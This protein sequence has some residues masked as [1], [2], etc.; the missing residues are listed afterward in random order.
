MGVLQRIE[1][2]LNVGCG[3]WILGRISKVSIDRT[4]VNPTGFGG[5]TG[6]SG[7]S[8]P[9]GPTG[10]GET[11]PTGPSGPSG[12][13]GPTGAGETGPT[14]NQGP[15]GPSGPTGP[16]GAGET[17]P[18]GLTG[19]STFSIVPDDFATPKAAIDA[20]QRRIF[21]KSGSYDDTGA[22]AISLS[23]V[24]TFLHI[25]GEGPA[26]T[27]WAFDSFVL[28]T[29]GVSA[30]FENL[31]LGNGAADSGITI[32]SG[33]SLTCRNIK[34]DTSLAGLLVASAAQ[35]Q[36][37]NG[38]KLKIDRLDAG[39]A[40]VPSGSAVGVV[41]D[42]LVFAV[43]T[44]NKIV[45]KDVRYQGA[46][47]N[48]RSFVFDLCPLN[49]S[50]GEY[51]LA[52]ETIADFERCEI[53]V[54]QNYDKRMWR[55]GSRV[56]Q[57][58]AVSCRGGTDQGATSAFEANVSQGDSFNGLAMFEIHSTDDNNGHG[59]KVIESCQ[60]NPSTSGTLAY[61]TAFFAFG[62]WTT[63][64]ADS[65]K[66]TLDQIVLRGNDQVFNSDAVGLTMARKGVE[67]TLDLTLRNIFITESNLQG[68][69]L[70]GNPEQF[71]VEGCALASGSTRLAAVSGSIQTYFE[72][73]AVGIRVNDN[74]LDGALF[75]GESLS[76]A[77][78][79]VFS[80]S[81]SG[82]TCSDGVTF[83][84]DSTLSEVA[85]GLTI[86]SNVFRDSLILAGDLV[87]TSITANSFNWDTAPRL[88]IEPTGE[89][90]NL[91]IT[92]NSFNKQ[93]PLAA[94]IVNNT[95]AAKIETLN[96]S[97]NVFDQEHSGTPISQIEIIN[98][99][100]HTSTTTDLMTF[101]NNTG[102]ISTTSGTRVVIVSDNANGRHLGSTELMAQVNR[103]KADNFTTGW[104]PSGTYITQNITTT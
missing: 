1:F 29:S 10:A 63:T 95:V 47:S 93:G 64:P 38:S 16:T 34:V 77:S 89:I 33:A 60:F 52:T 85:D 19:S 99:A 42:S 21:V 57:V 12:P 40:G 98:F 23:A 3:D 20:G 13:T 8:G 90:R 32:N 83:D 28:A 103:F 73:I 65:P 102:F 71:S 15:T 80:M 101:N 48:P 58:R 66:E 82:N 9:T 37:L 18:T 74:D 26:T 24:T 55:L 36:V 96:I 100:L 54:D 43:G 22:G 51:D 27:S 92:G 39:F 78:S 97:G 62:S 6:P 30:N 50:T 35:F 72:G 44:G 69:V 2:I 49:T 91:A 41:P 53:N 11:G 14:G 5:P 86:S 25:E 94:I 45:A 68:V 67:R 76:S 70:Y 75:E 88:G 7:P 31:T 79:H 4:S 17:G 87:N 46:G 81:F 59:P 61:D 104:S 56:S 84:F